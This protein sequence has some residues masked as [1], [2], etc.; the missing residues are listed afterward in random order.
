M[1]NTHEQDW[2]VLLR[3][4]L[5]EYP[6]LSTQ[7]HGQRV[8]PPA[9]REE[10]ARILRGDGQRPNVQEGAK[11]PICLSE[12]SEDLAAMPCKHVFHQECLR[13][14]LLRTNSCPSCR[15]ELITDDRDYEQ[16]KKNKDLIRQREQRVEELHNSMYS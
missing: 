8:A 7:F 1:I 12:L 3:H 5:E 4:L 6:E 15:L 14:W 11:C 16:F 13:Q 2:I 10:V 9:S